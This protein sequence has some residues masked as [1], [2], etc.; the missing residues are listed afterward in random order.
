M[1]E[2]RI[3]GSLEVVFEGGIVTPSGQKQ[4]ALL[5][6][7]AVAGGDLVPT[8]RL[9][10]ELWGERPPRTALTSLQNFVSQLRKALGPD[11]LE[12]RPHGYRLRLDQVNLDALRFQALLESARRAEPAERVRLLREGLE[13][14][15]GPAL[16]D[17]R[18]DSFAQNEA[19]RLDELRVVAQ[20]EA[21]TA[22]VELGRHADVVPEL[23]S[24]VRQ[25]PLRERPRAQL[26]LAL[27]RSGRQAEALDVYHDARRILGGELGIEPSP[28]LQRL[29][30]SILRQESQLEQS[31]PASAA[32]AAGDVVRTLLAG[33]LV[34]VVG[35]SVEPVDAPDV[36]EHLIKA[37]QYGDGPG[38]LTRVSQY[39]ATISGEGP[40][41][42]ALHE[43][44]GSD[45][46]P[47]NVHRFL[48][49]LPPILRAHDAPHQL[50][51]TTAYDLA[52]E[53]AF[54]EAGEMFDVVV[55]LAAGR[56]RGKFLH[57]APDRAP[58]LIDVPNT[59]ATELS[60]ERRTVILR[61][62]G[63]VDRGDERE[64]ESFV[65]TEDDYIGY[66]A[67][68]EL[69]SAIPVGLAARLRRSHFLF[70]GYAL[71]DWHMRLLLNRMWGDETVGY[72]SWSIQPEAS[73]LEKEFWRRRGLDVFEVALDDYVRT[74]EK[75]LTEV[76]V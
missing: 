1:V 64:W 15:R 59:Y 56:N 45:L 53:Q 55:Y 34:A 41:Y 67:P 25:E 22:E 61:L 10:E 76:P 69:A 8:D 71:R 20:E 72:R 17:F 32:D 74:L 3:L 43:L 68:G 54:T 29:Y 11:V 30:T 39:V 73:T 52:L 51:V 38:D 23:E 70:L 21:L 66:L 14:W 27:Y 24:L 35:P 13:L 6:I 44:Y 47:S 26:M 2:I 48:A 58:R 40:L 18:Y 7:L 16:A 5:A 9:I 31:R 57:L 36:V 65:V 49:S 75:R 46:S 60:L 4:R 19:R 12:T 62:H 28:G 42:D 33:R 37:F 63:R 50:I